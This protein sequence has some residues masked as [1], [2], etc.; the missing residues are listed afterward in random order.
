MPSLETIFSHSWV[1]QKNSCPA[2]DEDLQAPISYFP[3]TKRH[4]ITASIS[5][6]HKTLMVNDTFLYLK[7]KC[8]FKTECEDLFDHKRY[9]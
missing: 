3:Y 9:Q 6:L 7:C 4:F 1:D 5:N 8:Y 2:V